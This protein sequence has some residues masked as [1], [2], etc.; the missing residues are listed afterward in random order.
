M[1]LSGEFGFTNRRSAAWYGMRQLL[2]PANGYDIALPP[3]DMLI[4]D[5]TTPKWRVTSGGR[6]QVESKDDFKKRL[7][8][9]PDHGDAVAMAYAVRAPV[10]EEMLAF[11][12]ERVEISAY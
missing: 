1:D 4:G 9:S 10:D 8:R 2:D 3:H 11:Y 12:E 7:G 6:V 5:L